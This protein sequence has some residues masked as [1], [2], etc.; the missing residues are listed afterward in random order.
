MFSKVDEILKTCEEKGYELY[1]LVLEE[2]LKTSKLTKEKI[3]A[4][5][6]EMLKIMEGSAKANLDS[7]SKTNMKMIDG[8]AYKMDQY[9][10]TGNTISGEFMTEAMAM[11]FSTLELSSSM[12]LIVASPTAGSSG[13]LPATLAS[14]KKR[15]NYSDEKLVNAMLTAI[16]IGK[17]IGKYGSFAGAEGGCQAETGSA[18]AMAAGAVVYLYGGSVEQS[19]HAASIAFIHV[20]GL[21]CDPIAGLVEYPCTF[22]N[23]SGVVNAFISADMAL[24]GIKSIVPFDEVCQ[25]VGEVGAGLPATLRET[26]LGGLAGTNT[27]REIRKRF[28]KSNE[29]L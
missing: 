9:S 11:A 16:G 25:A 18:S 1:E 28:L 14:M 2:E 13:I 22:R 23:A 26:G 20:L 19:F 29:E 15:N 10:K 5:L 24:A 21:V 7:P 8:F 27:G 6:E 3:R 17:I 4:E 12:G